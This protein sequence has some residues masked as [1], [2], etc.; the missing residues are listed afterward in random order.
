[1]PDRSKGYH[2]K[3]IMN[4]LLGVIKRSLEGFRYF[5]IKILIFILEDE[6]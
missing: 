1:M 5:L 4:S 6:M 2:N 3:V